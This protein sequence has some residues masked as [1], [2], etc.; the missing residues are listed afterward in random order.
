MIYYLFAILNDIL[1]ALGALLGLIVVLSIPTF[2]GFI[3]DFEDPDSNEFKF[4][5]KMLKIE[6]ISAAVLALLITF[7]PNQKQVAFIMAAPYIVEN[8]EL[9]DASKNTA[10]IIKLGTEYLKDILKE[11]TK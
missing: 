5:K 3:S 10:E 1:T 8:Q 11:T 2:A 7:L 6:A 4:I 9:H